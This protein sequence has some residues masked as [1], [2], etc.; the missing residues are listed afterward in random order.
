M[1][2]VPREKEQDQFVLKPKLLPVSNL[3]MKSSRRCGAPGGRALP[4]AWDPSE[5][6]GPFHDW[7]CSFIAAATRGVRWMGLAWKL[8]RWNGLGQ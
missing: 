4:S 7:Q 6:E 8:L 3:P 5:G 2:N 1:G